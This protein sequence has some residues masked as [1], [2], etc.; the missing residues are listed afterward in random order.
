MQLG[1]KEAPDED[2][3]KNRQNSNVKNRR[4]I[5]NGPAPQ[6]TKYF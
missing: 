3:M 2:A 6:M 4:A 5:H 1:A